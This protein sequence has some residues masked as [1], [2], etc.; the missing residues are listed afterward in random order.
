MTVDNGTAASLP[1][2]WILKE[3][4]EKKHRNNSK[5]VIVGWGEVAKKS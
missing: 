1:G 5:E 3:I 4:H 2:C